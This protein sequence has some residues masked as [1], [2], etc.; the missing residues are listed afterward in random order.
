MQPSTPASLPPTELSRDAAT[1]DHKRARERADWVDAAKGIGIVLVVVGHGTRGLI[2][3]GLLDESSGWG[4][5]NYLIYTFHMPLFFL[6][7]GLFVQ[8]RLGWNPSA[9]V[10]SAV[11]RIAWPYVLWSAI[12]LAVIDAVGTLVNRPTPLDAQR[13]IALLWEPTSQF[14]FLHALLLLHIASRLV[15]PRFGAAPLLAAL[16]VARM[17]V[18]VVDVPHGIGQL[19]RFGP[20]YALGVLVGSTAVPLLAAMRRTTALA[21]ALG[22]LSVWLPAALAAHAFGYGFWSLAAL[23]AALAGCAATVAVSTLLRGTLKQWLVVAGQC[24]M[25]IYVLHVMLVAGTRIALDKGLGLGPQDAHVI[26]AVAITVGLLGPIVLR[27]CAV[28]LN[29]ARPLGLG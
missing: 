23:P 17:L 10:S 7:A 9:F 4:T 11:S 5:A 28:H 15:V 13:L 27:S 20:Y 18:S 6:L 26:L 25:A 22:S 2:D 16:L 1:A 24:S 3:A 8:A 21:M 19:C 14:W 12:Q 29:V